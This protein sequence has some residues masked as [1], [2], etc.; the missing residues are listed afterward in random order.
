MMSGWSYVIVSRLVFGGGLDPVRQK[1]QDGADPQQRGETAKEL[2][3]ELDPLWG[4]GWRGQGIWAVPS[5]DL[6]SPCGGQSLI[7]DMRHNDISIRRW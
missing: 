6:P 7:E 1:A 2:L 3:A 5:Q 4:G